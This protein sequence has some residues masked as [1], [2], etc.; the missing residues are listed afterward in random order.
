[1]KDDLEDK[2][3]EELKAFEQQ[4]TREIDVINEMRTSQ[5]NSALNA[6]GEAAKELDS[7]R[8]IDIRANVNSR[9]QARLDDLYNQLRACQTKIDRFTQNQNRSNGNNQL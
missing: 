2:T 3:L 7:P 5:I 1:M 6:A 4:L 9:F 8:Q